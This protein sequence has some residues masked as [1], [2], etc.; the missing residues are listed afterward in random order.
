MIRFPLLASVLLAAAGCSPDFDPASHVEKLRVLAV[1]AEPPEIA[2]AADGTAP[3]RTALGAL[4]AH[5][6]FVA[7]PARRAVV[8]HLACTPMPGNPTPLPCAV[9]DALAAP[10]ALLAAADLAGACT[11]PGRGTMGALTF[12]GLE[13]CGLE[14]CVPLSVR[15]DPGDPDSAVELPAPAY[16]LPA[17]FDL[18]ALPPGT[19]ERVLGTEVTALAL[20]LDASP[21]DLAPAAS[22]PDACSALAEVAS[23][24][25]AL[26]TAR[27]HVS[28]LKRIRVRG[29]DALNTPNVNPEISGV[30]LDG[31]TL[32]APGGVPAQIASGIE[33]DLLPL[34]PGDPDVLR[35]TYVKC[36]AAGTP[37]ET[38]VEEW[39][40]S[41]FATAG[42]LDDLHT[43]DAA[44]P[45]PFTPPASGRILVH[46]V[47][48]DLR[49]GIGWASGVAEVAP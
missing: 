25:G 39:T 47:V 10:D 17:G 8:L 44:E 16:L 6:D 29:P 31:A 4:V 43:R 23:R 19:P 32:P 18:A 28:V 34:L 3:D 35:E 38:A 42:E 40:F 5:P 13:A 11:A 21:D 27:D 22:V 9:L 46:A 41:W 1:R 12:A 36:D 2:P 7:D 30:S 26:W 33:A 49:G 24:F 15:T 37:I 45:D 48:R 20:A 14:G